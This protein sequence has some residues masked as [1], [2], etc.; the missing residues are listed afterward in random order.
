MTYSKIIILLIIA[1]AL[2]Y[3]KI[4]KSSIKGKIGEKGVSAF[5]SMLPGKYIVLND[6]MLRN[7]SYTTQIDHIVISP[8]GIFVIETKNYKGWILGGFHSEKWTQNIWGHKY[9]LYNPILQNEKHIKFLLRKYPNLTSIYPHIY[10]IVVFVRANKLRISGSGDAVVIRPYG[11]NSY[12]KSFDDDIL[13]CGECKELASD[14]YRD[15]ITDSKERKA[16]KYRANK[17]AIIRNVRI[18]NGIYLS[19]VRWSVSAA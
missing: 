15:N 9:E 13:S 10:S 8:H 11:I 3:F 7:G 4:R 17:S 2:V 6:I 14:I 16:H 1:V 18:E 19:S 5:L 12:I